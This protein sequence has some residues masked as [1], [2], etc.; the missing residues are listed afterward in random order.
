MYKSL[1]ILEPNKTVVFASP[2]SDSD[3]TLIRNG[4]IIENSF[5]HSILTSYSKE[6]LFMD[7][8]NKIS[9]YNKIKSDIFTIKESQKNSDTF[10]NLKKKL[11][12][13]LLYFHNF[14]NKIDIPIRDE[15]NEKILKIIKNNIVYDLFFDLI[16]FDGLKNIFNIEKNSY[17]EYKIEILDKIKNI[18]NLNETLLQVDINKKESIIKNVIEIIDIIFQN[19]EKNIYIKYYK[20]ITKYV[21]VD[22]IN[23]ISKKLNIDIYFIDAKTRLPIIFDP[24]QIYK[25]R[26]S[27]IILKHDND[28][29]ETIGLLLPLDKIQRE[30]ESSEKI[31]QK[32]NMFLFNKKKLKEKY[33]DLNKYILNNQKNNF[34]S[35]DSESETKSNIKNFNKNDVEVKKYT[36]K[37]KDIQDNNRNILINKYR[38]K[39]NKFDK[40]I[41]MENKNI[42]NI[43]NDSDDSDY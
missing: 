15:C 32:I 41:N 3:I 1:S 19:I 24:N 28:K 18:L 38:M 10:K 13:I 23:L 14:V 7:I 12:E 11:N 34:D 31:I 43:N 17:K 21:N 4:V 27:A 42:D 37:N 16:P 39:I 2:M 35:D 8:S 20:N 33:P 30:F 9:Y 25:N 6:Y 26:K 40:N 5:F 36:I 22:L 29:Y